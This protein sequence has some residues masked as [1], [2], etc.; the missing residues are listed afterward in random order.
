MADVVFLKLLKE[1]K[2][3]FIAILVKCF[4]MISHQIAVRLQSTVQLFLRNI[5]LLTEFAQ[6]ISEQEVL[7]F[8]FASLRSY[9]SWKPPSPSIICV[10]P[11]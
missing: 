1:L 3:V 7:Y 5:E 8:L 6:F 4:P 2:I 9:F 11:N 10:H